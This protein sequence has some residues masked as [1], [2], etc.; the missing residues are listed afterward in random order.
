[1]TVVDV[2][3]IFVILLSALF[4]LMRGFVKEAISLAT[5]ILAMWVAGHFSAK[6][7][8]KLPIESEAVQQVAA[9]G[10][11]FV[12]ALLV[13]VLVNV[14]IAKFVKKT[15]LSSA[16]R[17]LGVVFGFLRGALII[18]VFVVIGGMTA[19][20]QQEW[21]QTSIM[22]ERF[23]RAAVMLEDYFPDDVMSFDGAQDQVTDQISNQVRN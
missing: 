17:V 5:W 19:L 8:P 18:V 12:L 16:D 6:L 14:V 3:I 7:A 20:P 23:E 2:V 21:W 9:F 10:V 15:G 13:G 11:L 22:L 4:S 1:M